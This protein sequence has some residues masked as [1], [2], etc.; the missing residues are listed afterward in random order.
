MGRLPRRGTAQKVCYALPVLLVLTC[1]CNAMYSLLHACSPT[2]GIRLLCQTKALYVSLAGRTRG[3]HGVSSGA[4]AARCS[5]GALG[6]RTPAPYVCL[7]GP[8]SLHTPPNHEFLR[9][10]NRFGTVFRIERL[11]GARG[12]CDHVAEV[13][14]ALDS[15]WKIID[16]SMLCF[17]LKL[18]MF[19]K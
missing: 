12:A 16:A 18:S 7:T 13:P 14:A 2:S 3:G 19:E 6:H 11:H 8:P 1:F 15:R 4:P 9:I 17:L 10:C 5:N